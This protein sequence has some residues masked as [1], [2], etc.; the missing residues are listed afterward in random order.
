[1]SLST[2]FAQIAVHGSA[3]DRLTLEIAQAEAEV[4]KAAGGG[5]PDEHKA[6]LEHQARLR[7]LLGIAKDAFE[8]WKDVVKTILGLIK[9]VNELA[10][11]SR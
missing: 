6:A 2:A 9:S 10:Q 7:A 3:V 8:F 4:I 1:M 11:G 5:K